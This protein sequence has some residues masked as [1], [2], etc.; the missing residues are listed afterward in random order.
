MSA[1]V[2]KK[3]HAKLALVEIADHISEDSLD[4]ALRF[5]GAAE[6]GERMQRSVRLIPKQGHVT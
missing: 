2:N 3:P 5:I 1:F 4:S 6:V